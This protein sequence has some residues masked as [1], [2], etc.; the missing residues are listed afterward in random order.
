MTARFLAG[1]VLLSLWAYAQQPS[2]PEAKYTIAGVVV[3]H[4]TN[5]AI[6]RVRVT[7]F[8]NDHPDRRASLNTAEDGR[9]TFTGVP[10]GKYSLSAE[11]RGQQRMYE[12]DDQFSTGIVTGPGFDTTHIVFQFPAPTG[13][14]VK[15]SDDGGE[16]VQQPQVVLF[17]KRILAGWAQMELAG[18]NF[19]AQGD[20]IIRFTHLEP[21]TYYAAASAR[22]WYAQNR[23]TPQGSGPQPES[24]SE[25]DVAYP[26]TYYS[27]TQDPQEAT[28]IEVQEGNANQLQIAL[29][30]VPATHLSVEGIGGGLDPARAGQTGTFIEAVG[31][32]GVRF[33]TNLAP[34]VF[35]G[36]EA[37]G[38][39]GLAPGKYIVSFASFGPEGQQPLGTLKVNAAANDVKVSASEILTTAVSGHIALENNTPPQGMSIWLGQPATGQNAF[40][41]IKQ[42]GS[43]SCTMSGAQGGNVA[44]G[45]YEVR[46]L[47]TTDLYL[48]SVGAKGA[49]YSSGLLDV[50]EGASIDLS[51]VAA[52]GL[53]Q[54]NGI[55]IRGGHALSGAMILLVPRDAGHGT[56]I[57]RDQSDSD[58]TFTLPNVKPG[59]YWLLA[60]DHGHDLEYHNPQVL[61]PYLSHAQTVEIPLPGNHPVPVNVQ[62][63][64]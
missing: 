34:Q 45:Q 35:D 38:I 48:K 25:L 27:N 8:Q 51:L 59:R 52:K 60:I 61:Q 33:Q 10:Q 56:G 23:G 12:E 1:A 2:A 19:G 62:A 46:L 47:N 40:C 29:H 14:T 63:R 6:K 15:V 7:I 4:A 20:G 37:R 30:P 42:D 44:P 39:T 28:P 43:F 13:L 49:V 22:P 9:F 3:H 24:A 18:Q 32:G 53:T 11:W 54:V 50:R 58:G 5:Q 36:G 31:P 16:P 26:I 64:R 41:P 57:P 17:H 55:A 21:G